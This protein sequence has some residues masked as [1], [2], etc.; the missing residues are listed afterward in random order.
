MTI[1]YNPITHPFPWRLLKVNK[2]KTKSPKKMNIARGKKRI[3]LD[4]VFA[5]LSFLWVWCHQ[6]TGFEWIKPRDI[7]SSGSLPY[8]YIYTSFTWKKKIKKS[9][10]KVGTVSDFILNLKAQHEFLLQEQVYDFIWN[11]NLAWCSPA[12][13]TISNR[14]INTKDIQLPQ[15]NYLLHSYIE[16]SGTF[17]S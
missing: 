14:E 4:F 17:K 7:Y 2:N 1:Y 12:V 11:W 10:L 3:M 9:K 6:G 15:S 13:V 5:C 8:M 16:K